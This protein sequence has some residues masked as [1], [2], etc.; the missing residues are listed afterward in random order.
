MASTSKPAIKPRRSARIR[1]K[2]IRAAMGKQKITDLMPELL[3][4][5]QSNL[6]LVHRFKSQR[7][8]KNWSDEVKETCKIVRH[9]ELR[10]EA[11]GSSFHPSTVPDEHFYFP[12]WNTPPAEPAQ[13]ARDNQGSI[14]Q[15]DSIHCLTITQDFTEYEAQTQAEQLANMFA[16][17]DSLFIWSR[18]CTI[19]RLQF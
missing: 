19:G 8:F 13:L 17:V 4:K 1:I 18:E 5:I 7:F 11:D 2:Q 6:S 3:R 15:A 16:G 9:L 14:F 12:Y 10:L